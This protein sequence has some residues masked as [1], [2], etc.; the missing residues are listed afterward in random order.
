MPQPPNLTSAADVAS[1]AAALGPCR[2]V[3]RL[4]H[5]GDGDASPLRR[6]TKA[7]EAVGRDVQAAL[8]SEGYRELQRVVGAAFRML[9]QF[10]GA[11]WHFEQAGADDDLDGLAELAWAFG[12]LATLRRLDGRALARGSQPV[13]G[14]A[15][16]LREFVITRVVP[17]MPLD[18]DQFQGFRFDV[19]LLD[20]AA[21]ALAPATVNELI[22]ESAFHLEQVGCEDEA[23]LYVLAT[24]TGDPELVARVGVR[25][26]RAVAVPR[27]RCREVVA[28]HF[29]NHR[30]DV[31]HEGD[32]AGVHPRSRFVLSLTGPDGTRSILKEVLPLTCEVPGERGFAH[33][34]RILGSCPIDGVPP[35]LDVMDVQG[36]R[37]L[38]L[39]FLPG[40]NLR[41]VLE[42]DGLPPPARALRL[43]T[44][45][46]RIL[47]E[48]HER[49][50][51]HLDLRE[52]CLLWDG[53]TVGLVGFDRARLLQGQDEAWLT[54]GCAAFAAP[55]TVRRFRAGTA[56]D[57]FALG[58]L[59]HRLLTGRAPFG[60]PAVPAPPGG[61][62][63]RLLLD[64]ALPAL[65]LEPD[66][67]RDDLTAIH[68]GL[69]SLVEGLLRKDPCRRTTAE[70]ALG[71]LRE[72]TGSAG[73]A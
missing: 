13:L 63:E 14:S 34:D 8:G 1:R 54:P 42:R 7:L 46:S 28:G 52:D 72:M 50:T 27:N 36:I 53:Q 49:G 43:L 30:V 19:R 21:S 69:P 65:F 62:P 4:S 38:R 9:R 22:R 31:I 18:G 11:A 60:R 5:T 35:L 6:L 67:R 59:A 47:T 56:A 17:A 57:C 33:E 26:G 58:L 55:E 51:A 2:T 32:A 66:L 70:G 23:K 10:G 68:D 61:E 25:F 40:R 73:G 48:L 71:A 41:L 3:L 64:F 20:D 24:R 29:P 12:D 15:S 45:L 44:D 39:G 16:A 37:F